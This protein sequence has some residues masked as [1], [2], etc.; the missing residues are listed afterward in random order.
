M[1]Y[2][3]RYKR[4]FMR[5]TEEGSQ[6]FQEVIREGEGSRAYNIFN[7]RVRR[8]PDEAYLYHVRVDLNSYKEEAFTNWLSNWGYETYADFIDYMDNHTML[9]NHELRLA[10]CVADYDTLLEFD[11]DT[12]GSVDECIQRLTDLLGGRSPYDDSDPE[13]FAEENQKNN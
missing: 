1:A 4:D 8:Y 10:N 2:K 13:E 9:H 5:F 6:D 11:V 12:K 7:F 3:M